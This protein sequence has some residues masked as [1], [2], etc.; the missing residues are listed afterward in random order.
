MIP[1]IFDKEF[2]F[3]IGFLPKTTLTAKSDR[4]QSRFVNCHA[5]KILSLTM[6]LII[7]HQQ[8]QRYAI[9][10][11]FFPS[12]CWRGMPLRWVLV[13]FFHPWGFTGSWLILTDLGHYSSLAKPAPWPSLG[14]LWF[15]GRSTSKRFVNATDMS[16]TE[17][18]AS[19]DLR[20]AL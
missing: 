6:N 2:T 12:L 17:D 13:G 8:Q 9:A 20:W 3:F 16:F 4:E 15:S 10:M 19:G 14:V 18:A 1:G 11:C 5:T 7:H